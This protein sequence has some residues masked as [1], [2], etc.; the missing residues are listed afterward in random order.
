MSEQ[1]AAH[2]MALV[3]RADDLFVTTLNS[4]GYPITRVMF[5]LHNP[6]RF[7]QQA[8]Y[9]R[10]LRDGCLY[11]GTNTSSAKVAQLRA[12]PR[13]TLY[14]HPSG[15]WEGVCIV[16]DAEEVADRAVK[17]GLWQDEWTMYYPGGVADPDFTVIRVHP[18]FAEY[19]HEMHKDVIDFQAGQHADRA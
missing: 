16:G 2:A 13:I 6:T 7:P 18:L 3:E 19:Y 8:A 5:N 11:L 4:A 15:S 10:A 14:V 17:Q 12:N 1:H 9:L